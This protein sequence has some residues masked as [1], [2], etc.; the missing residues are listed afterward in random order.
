MK[1]ISHFLICIILINISCTKT[2]RDVHF[3]GRVTLTC[4]NQMP[5]KNYKINISRFYD[6]GSEGAETIGTASTDNNGYYSL[7]TNVKQKGSL[8]YYQYRDI[9]GEIKTVSSSRQYWVGEAQTSDNDNDIEV[10][11][12]GYSNKAYKFH[13]KNVSP[14]NSGD[15]F[16]SLTVKRLNVNYYL[17][18]ISNLIGTNVDTTT[19][20][21]YPGVQLIYEYSYTKNGVLTSVPPDTLSIPDCLDTLNV[22]VFY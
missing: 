18:N 7:I 8:M 16:N 22:D 4:N 3:H 19:Y 6:T 17:S 1:R 9:N 10:N 15:V 20:Q 12:E 11:L 21:F 13:I 14:V 5:L 2:K